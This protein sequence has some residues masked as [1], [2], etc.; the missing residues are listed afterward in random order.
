MAKFSEYPEEVGA[1]PEGFLL[2]AVEQPPGSPA[3]LVTKK[4]RPDRIGAQGPTGP[5]GLPG[6]SGTP[7]P[8]GAAGAAGATGATGAAGANGAAGAAGQ[9][10]YVVGAG[11]S[12]TLGDFDGMA[13]D[14]FEQYALGA[15]TTTDMGVGW[16]GNGRVVGGT[17]VSRTTHGG[18]VQKR[19]SLATNAQIG[20]TLPWA[21]KWNKVRLG[22]L[23][24]INGG[25]NFD[26]RWALGV[27]SGTAAMFGDFPPTTNWF[28]SS[29]FD[30]GASD[31]WVFAAGVQQNTLISSTYEGVWRRGAVETGTGGSFSA[32]PMGFPATEASH[33]SFILDINRGLF[34]GATAIAYNLNH[35][36]SAT[37]PRAQFHHT[38]TQFLNLM[39]FLAPATENADVL[40]TSGNYPSPVSISEA[41]GVF[42]TFNF[43]WE[44]ATPIEIV[45]MAAYKMY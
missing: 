42:D 31:N 2:M 32:S 34:T 29:Q 22:I 11:I 7:G 8:T 38:R 18:F 12:P 6:G 5:Q 10:G 41:T 45:G 23:A 43:W 26:G 37:D 20:R 28:G 1:N 44:A 17:I 33:T 19:L 36:S 39:H 30:T 16:N 3:P 13:V 14:L 4:I 15:I 40:L 21:G 24:R 35:S 25:A 27:S 9:P